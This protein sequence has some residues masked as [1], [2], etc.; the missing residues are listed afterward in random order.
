MADSPHT[1]EATEATEAIP[2]ICAENNETIAHFLVS[3]DEADYK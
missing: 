2:S 1:T 3:S